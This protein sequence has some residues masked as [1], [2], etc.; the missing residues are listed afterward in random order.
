LCTAN[1]VVTSK[2]TATNTKAVSFKLAAK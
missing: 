1:V 2:S